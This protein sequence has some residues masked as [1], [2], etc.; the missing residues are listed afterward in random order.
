[1]KTTSKL[2]ANQFRT[3]KYIHKL[4]IRVGAEFLRWHP[5]NTSLRDLKIAGGDGK[6]RPAH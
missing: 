3:N 5:D 1:M 4:M 6:Q 2:Q